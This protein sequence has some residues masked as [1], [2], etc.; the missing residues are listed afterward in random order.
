MPEQRTTRSAK[1]ELVRYARRA[2]KVGLFVSSS[3][4]MSIRIDGSRFAVTSSG[5]FLDELEREDICI[6]SITREG[7]NCWSPSIE[8]SLH[9]AIYTERG[10]ISAIL[11]FQSLYATVLACARNS[12]FRI[13]IIPEIPVYIKSIKMIPFRHP[14][15]KELAEEV[16][17]A[18]RERDNRILVLQGH[19]QIAVGEDLRVVVRNAEFFEFAC[20]MLCQGI[21]LK[22]YDR[23]TIKDLLKFKHA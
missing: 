19:G 17:K 5:A 4:N 22:R 8:L 7:C 12:D 11:H 10:D 18:V 2:G 13:H 14:G 9:R 6:C 3:G 21:T 20:R 23:K 1:S 15:S 16:R